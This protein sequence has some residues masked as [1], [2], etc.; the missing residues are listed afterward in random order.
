MVIIKGEM[1][2]P[3]WVITDDSIVNVGDYSCY[4]AKGEIAGRM[5][6]VWFTPDIPVNAGPWKLWGLPG[7]IVKA[8]SDDHVLT[9]VLKSLEQ[10]DMSM[11]EPDVEKTI[12]KDEFKKELKQDIAKLTRFFN[13]IDL[14]S[15]NLQI[16]SNVSPD[17]WDKSL[18][19]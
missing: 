11:I 15:R 17:F 18:T 13:S 19:E 2:Q 8:E 5:Y 1:E 10:C 6:T 12:S 16:S 14:G 4:K 7:L 9:F 3:D